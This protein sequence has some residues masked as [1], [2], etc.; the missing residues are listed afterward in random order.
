[1]CPAE[2]RWTEALPLALLCM[3][4]TFIEDLQVSVA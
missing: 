4:T 2:E 1:M 3:R